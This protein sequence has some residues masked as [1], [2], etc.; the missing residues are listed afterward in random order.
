MG[1]TGSPH[2][3]SSRELRGRGRGPGG[4]SSFGLESGSDAASPQ[5]SPR[6]QR[7]QRSSGMRRPSNDVADAGQPPVRPSS[8]AVSGLRSRVTTHDR[9]SSSVTKGPKSRTTGLAQRGAQPVG[10]DTNPAKAKAKVSAFG[11]SSSDSDGIGAGIASLVVEEKKPVAGAPDRSVEQ[12]A[13]QDAG[14]MAMEE[15]GVEDMA[16]E[17]MS[18]EEFGVSDYHAPGTTS[19]VMKGPKSGSSFGGGGG[20]GAVGKGRSSMAIDMKTAAQLRTLMC[21]ATRHIFLAARLQGA[22]GCPV[23]SQSAQGSPP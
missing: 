11:D 3:L 4:R 13:A 9:P 5:H 7:R 12:A 19:S 14:G 16:I 6:N 23:C 20:G 1:E 22:V 18:V 15:I 21:V 17:D 2:R 10:R 8:A